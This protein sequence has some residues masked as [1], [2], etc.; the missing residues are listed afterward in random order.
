MLKSLQADIVDLRF[1]VIVLDYSE[2]IDF[3]AN[4]P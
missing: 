3:F 1:I 2:A 4:I